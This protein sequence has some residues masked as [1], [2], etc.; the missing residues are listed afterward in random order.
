MAVY[1]PAARAAAG[2]VDEIEATI[3]SA[4]D[5]TNVA[6]ANGGVN[7]FLVLVHAE[8]VGHAEAASIAADLD[9]VSGSPAV[10]ALRDAHHADVVSLIVAGGTSCGISFVQTDPDPSFESSAFQVTRLDCAFANLTLAHEIAH[11][12]G[13]EHNPEDSVRWPSGASFPWSFGHYHHGGYRTVMSLST[14]CSPPCPR[15]PYFSN[16]DVDFGGLPTGVAG[17]RENYRTLNE[18]A[19]I[20]AGFRTR[21]PEIF[22]DDFESGGLAAW[23]CVSALCE[24]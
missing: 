17:T 19:W 24:L 5:V 7:A 23:S 22:A 12:Q 11:L 9:W 3:R 4:V 21:P 13:A 2:G 16:P 8:E 1:T 20:V 10:A 15:Q 14:P 6:Y 18:T